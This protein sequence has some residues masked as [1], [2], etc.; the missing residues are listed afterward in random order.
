MVSRHSAGGRTMHARRYLLVPWLVVSLAVVI[1]GMSLCLPLVSAQ[2]SYGPPGPK[3]DDIVQ[4]IATPTTISIIV[5]NVPVAPSPTTAVAPST[6]A[7]PVRP[8]S[9]GLLT[10][11][12]QFGT[13]KR[14]DEPYG[15]FVQAADQAY[16]SPYSGKLS[17][18]FPTPGNDYVVFRRK[19]PMGGA[20]QAVTAWVYGDNSGHYLNCWVRDAAGELWSFP[21]GRIQHTGWQQMTAPL[22]VNGA[23][24]TGHVSGPANG[25]LD[26]PLDFHA[27]VLDDAPDSYTGAGSIYVDD[28]SCSDLAYS[29]PA[30]PPSGP[31]QP[32]A[33]PLQT[34]AW[35]VPAQSSS[36]CTVTLLDPPEGSQFGG[37]TE[38]VMLKWQF[39]RQLDPNEYFFVNVEF[40]HGGA[41]WY[42]GTWRDPGQQLPDGTRDT[43]WI[44]RDYLCQPGFSDTG[45]YKWYVV[46]MHQLGSEKR[47]SDGFVC[48]SDKRNFKWS[49]CAPT[50]E[51]PSGGK[52]D[53]YVRRMDYTPANPTVGD[54]IQM[55][56]MIATDIGPDGGPFFP[57]SHFRWRTDTN[58]GW[59][60]ESCP[61]SNHYASCLKTINFSYGQPGDYTVKVVADSQGEVDETD[62]GNNAKKWTISVG[63]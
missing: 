48:R 34:P 42:D 36:G 46:V 59:N 12:D 2:P 30:A 54:N 19:I 61:E 27:I 22:D 33:N 58:T 24:P 5:N 51:P 17:Y 7:A 35:S 39:N 25:M 28:I 53:L 47:L 3:S 62:E 14:G 15:S 10:N 63:P 31:S 56:V 60:E 21:F 49:G 37:E 29:S 9:C 50:P 18:S 8:A 40:P 55:G 13:W 26:Y 20:G 16:S 23:W 4:G 52:Y 32:P 1:V 57:A 45:W 11:F 44:L 43:S 6:V 41:T 38:N